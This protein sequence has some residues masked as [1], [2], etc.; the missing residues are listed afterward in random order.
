MV[1]LLGSLLGGAS[2][3][4]VCRGLLWPWG[5]CWGCSLP[6]V[7]AWKATGNPRRP[8]RLGPLPLWFVPLRCRLLPNPHPHPQS[9]GVQ[10]RIARKDGSALETVPDCATLFAN[11]GRDYLLVLYLPPDFARENI[12]TAQFVVDGNRVEDSFV[13]REW[14]FPKPLPGGWEGAVFKLSDLFASPPSEHTFSPAQVSELAIRL[15]WTASGGA[16]ES[17]KV[18]CTSTPRAFEPLDL[19]TPQDLTLVDVFLYYDSAAEEGT[20]AAT[21][22]NL[23]GR[24]STPFTWVLEANGVTIQREVQRAILPGACIDVVADQAFSAFGVQQPG[25][26]QVRAEVKPAVAEDPAGNDAFTATLEVT[27]ISTRPSQEALRAYQRCVQK[28]GLYDPDGYPA[29]AHLLNGAPLADLDEVSA[30]KENFTV[31]AP[32]ALS[33]IMGIVVANTALCGEGVFNLFPWADAKA[34]SWLVLAHPE[35]DTVQVPYHASAGYVYILMKAG[36]FWFSHPH[37]TQGKCADLVLAHEFVHA[38]LQRFVEKDRFDAQ[39][40]F[41]STGVFFPQSLH[42][43]LAF[44]GVGKVNP[45]PR[46]DTLQ[47]EEKGYFGGG[48]L[49]PYVPLEQL[50]DP[51]N[52]V[53]WGDAQMTAACF[54]DYIDN[55]YGTE[56][57]VQIIE[58][59]ANYP[60]R[61]PCV[62]FLDTFVAPVIGKEDYP[63]FQERFG[64]SPELSTCDF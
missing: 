30:Q 49:I 31:V 3:V 14:L 6:V 15:G 12:A 48:M 20:F 2:C 27:R 60:A 28:N 25:Q 23:G 62:S 35:S 34:E 26:V 33:N 47:C 5:R 13:L 44:W 59:M 7:L 24:T 32:R 54:W 36:D 55:K 16:R 19:G 52:T 4:V 56:A 64:I 9:R 51:N 41:H 46:P 37:L 53:D 42:E 45:Q 18:L 43:G 39:G 38:F 40:V 61:D 21:V 50:A 10:I 11:E 17:T 63:V 1:G 58:T 8:R 22:C 29:C 57:V